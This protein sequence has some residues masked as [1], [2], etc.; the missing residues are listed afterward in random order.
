V[1]IGFTQLGL[2]YGEIAGAAA[3][4][5]W[6]ASVGG[7]LGMAL[8]VAGT[9]LL[10]FGLVTNSIRIDLSIFIYIHLSICIYLYICIHL[11]MYIYIYM[12]MYMYIYLPIYNNL[13]IYLSI[14]LST[15]LYL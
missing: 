9:A 4:I 14:Y 5:A 8:R 11:Y 3:L 2:Q 6:S 1:C 10:G 12:Y 13:S 7:P 15:Y